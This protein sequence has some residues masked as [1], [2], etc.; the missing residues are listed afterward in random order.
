MNEQHERRLRRK[1]IR[2]TLR[3]VPRHAILAQ[4]RRS[5]GWLAKWQRRFATDG[6]AG[7][8]SQSRQPHHV[9]GR[10]P[11]RTRRLV[12]DARQRLAKRTVGLVGAQAIQDELRRARLLRRIPA[13]ATIKRILRDAGVIKRPRPPARSYFPQPTATTTYVVHAMDWTARYLPGG[14]KVFA[15]HTVDLQ[16]RALHQTLRTDKTTATVREHAL[17]AWQA[18]GLPDGLQMDNDAAFNGGYKVPRGFGTFVRLCLYLGIEPI[19]IP[20]GEPD[21][22]AVIERLN[23]VWSQAFWQRQHFQ[24]LP[25]VAREAPTFVQWYAEEY[26]PAALAGA[27]PAQAHAQVPRRYLTEAEVSAL[28]AKLPITAGRVHFIRCVDADGAISLLNETWHVDK[29]LH[30]QYVW[31]TVVTHRHHLAIYHRRAVRD[32]VRMVKTWRYPLPEPVVPV[33]DRFARPYRRRNM[34]TML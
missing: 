19:F 33:V 8:H 21:R 18:L 13:V 20:V 5:T 3:G 34:F 26:H 25:H 14:T 12:L 24:D 30:G 1:A 27:T 7:L 22:N 11:P 31:A 28:P 9:A 29:R 16:T 10:Y 15:F 32:A 4:L 23:G 17:A 6:W 2:L